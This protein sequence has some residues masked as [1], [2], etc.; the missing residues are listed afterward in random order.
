MDGYLGHQGQSVR[1]TYVL[2][3]TA[4]ASTIT[5]SSTTAPHLLSSLHKN[6]P[7]VTSEDSAPAQPASHDVVGDFHYY[8]D[9][10]DGS[11]PEPN[12]VSQPQ[13]FTERPVET[14]SKLVHDIRGEES[15]YSLDKTGFE[16]YKHAS[17]EKDFLDEEQIKTKYYAET[18][19]LLKKA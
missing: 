11:E 6:E 18:E 7:Q 16:I 14:R 13:T 5:P 4:M 3:E 15:Q 8:K 19:D 17:Q 9:P 2:L 12:I 1:T 10:G